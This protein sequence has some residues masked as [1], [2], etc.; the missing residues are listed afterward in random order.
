[1]NRVRVKIAACLASLLMASSTGTATGDTII[2]KSTTYFSIGGV[3]AS[4]LDRELMRRGPLSRT[5]GRRHPGSNP[6]QVQWVGNLCFKGWPMPHRWRQGVAID[7]DHA[8]EV[9]QPSQG[10]RPDGA[11][12]GYTVVGYPPA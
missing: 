3:T 7:Q 10:W 2:R 4:D 9:V 6:N 1:M 12:V 5:T 8:A 11:F